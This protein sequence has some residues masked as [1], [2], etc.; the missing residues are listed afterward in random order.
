MS[1]RV[2]FNCDTRDIKDFEEFAQ[3]AKEL[4]ATHMDITQIPKSRWQWELDRSDPYP[5]WGM[6]KP[7][8]FKILIPDKLKGHLNQEYSDKIIG[9]LR[10]RAEVLK[11]L[12]L[13]AAYAGSDPAW[14]PESV[15]EAYPEWRGPRCEHPRRARRPYYSP[16]ID[17]P[18]VLETYIGT[19]EKLCRIIPIEHFRFLINDSGGG[20]CW[21]RNLYAGPNGPSACAHRAFSQRVTGFL[22]AI[23]EGTR[24]AGLEASAGIGA[25][26]LPEDALATVP[27]LKPGQF[28]TNL[29]PQG[30]A[31]YLD[32]GFE[33]E[34]YGTNIYPVDGIPQISLFAE[35][36]QRSFEKPETDVIISI[37]TVGR[38]EHY[39]FIKKFRNQ[40][41]KGVTGRY[42]AL[43]EVA[44][45]LA[46]EEFAS[47][48][49]DVWDYLYK[50][51]ENM[52]YIGNGGHILL[53][54]CVS[55]RWLTR[56]FVPFPL[57]LEPEERDYFRRFQFQANSEEEAG[58]LMN[59]Q[60]QEHVNGY[61]G[62][63]FMTK[64]MKISIEHFQR[65]LKALVRILDKMP[66][67]EYKKNLVTLELRIKTLICT[68]RNAINAC[69]YQEILDRTDYTAVPKDSTQVWID[70]GD[71][72]LREIQNVTRDEI[73]NTQELIRLLESTSES[74]LVMAASHEEEDVFTL[75]PDLIHQMKK[76]IKIM[77]DHTMDLNR[78]YTRFNN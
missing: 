72:K 31:P 57:E 9:I 11:K 58:D 77:M 12:G 44:A 65:A 71:P 4:G 66:E 7:S 20:V 62:M 70:Q 45:S 15:Y 75:G 34:Y 23:Q 17:N 63:W 59:I 25:I 14:L 6:D 50:G 1:R 26:V 53:M 60:G 19:V 2:I 48:L 51:I 37:P 69:R 16:C 27:Y 78:L 46:G 41:Y 29:D 40:P 76:K 39:E 55:Q 13:K 30:Q 54:G 32:M 67:G 56:P 5:N 36:M 38:I 10:Q 42:N 74:L 22:D 61:S 49:V 68:V 43:R 33:C 18:E 35:R 8:I 52:R 28:I 73:D 24:R 47:D 3:K 64:A 21:S